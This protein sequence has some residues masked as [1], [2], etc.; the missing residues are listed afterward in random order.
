MSD[1]VPRNDLDAGISIVRCE[2]GEAPVTPWSRK[3]RLPEETAQVVG[4]GGELEPNDVV[5][6]G[7]TEEPHPW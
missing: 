1:S 2:V 3:Y 7:V 6:G 4:E 5:D